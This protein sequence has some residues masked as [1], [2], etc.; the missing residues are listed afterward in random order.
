VLGSAEMLLAG[1]TT[2]CEMYFFEH[3]MVDA[4][5]CTGGR[6]VMTPAVVSALLPGGDVVP[7]IAE[8]DS[9]FAQYHDPQGRITV[10]FAPHSPYDLEPRQVAQIARQAQAV[11][12]LL[13]IHMEE[14]QA[15][16]QL[17]FDRHGCSATQLL[18]EHGVLEGPVLAAHG[19]WLD[20]ADQRLLAEA[21]ASVAHCPVSNLK[22]G[23]G[24]AP[25]VDFVNRGINVGLGTDGAASNDS[26]DLWEELKLAPLLA[27][28]T[29]FDPAAMD[30]VAA[31][32]MATAS[33][34]K[35]VQLPDVGELRP[36]AWADVVRLDIDQPAFTPGVDL[37]TN[38]VFAGS[39]RHVTDVWV[40]GDRVVRDGASTKVDL[41]EVV[42]ECRTRG[43]RL[44]DSSGL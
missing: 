41:G 29:R 5:N 19:V 30:A 21:G 23:S 44:A 6:L 11:G 34:A 38:V 13:H 25:V 36:G 7:R 20:P 28:G 14:T 35:A 24:I 27:R 40:A 22:L 4:I 10:G 26:L 31:L 2:S 1:V 42:L 32:D 12:A 3:A 16:R 8:L 18:A 39:S 37:L 33:A 17:V 15:E 43:K 9:L